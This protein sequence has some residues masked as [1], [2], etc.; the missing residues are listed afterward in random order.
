MTGEAPQLEEPIAPESQEP[1]GQP[2]QPLDFD[3][4]VLRESA[5][6]RQQFDSAHEPR[7]QARVA[8]AEADRL[9]MGD[10][11]T[12]MQGGDPVDTPSGY[13]QFA[14]PLIQGLHQ[15]ALMQRVSY[16]ANTALEQDE[17]WKA[18]QSEWD[19]L[20][21]KPYEAQ[22]ATL[23]D[24]PGQTPEE[25]MLI[26]LQRTPVEVDP[27]WIA[28]LRM[29][30]LTLDSKLKEASGGKVNIWNH[31]RTRYIAT[32]MNREAAQGTPGFLRSGQQDLGVQ[33]V[34][35]DYAVE[36]ALNL[37]SGLLDMPVQVAQGAYGLIGE[38]VNGITGGAVGWEAPHSYIETP[39]GRILPNAERLP[40][41]LEMF[42]GMRALALGDDV[43][44]QMA[45]W[46]A[47][48]EWQAAQQSGFSQV[49][50]GTALV[51]G[52]IVGLSPTVKAGQRIEKMMNKGLGMVG[53]GKASKNAAQSSHLLKVRDTMTAA[54]GQ[55]AALAMQDALIAGRPEKL[56]EATAHGFKSGLI[57]FGIG[58][59]GR[60]VEHLM[61]TRA[62]MPPRVAEAFGAFTE[63]GLFTGTELAEIQGGIWNFIRD[64][65]ADTW[66]E[67]DK[68]LMKNFLG[69][70][71]A[72]GAGLSIGGEVSRER[73]QMARERTE[74]GDLAEKVLQAKEAAEAVPRET[75]EKAKEPKSEL[76]E[77]ELEAF[78]LGGE[79]VR[80]ESTFDIPEG[81]I[82]GRGPVER[83]ASEAPKVERPKD[84]PLVSEAES[85]MLEGV[86]RPEKSEFGEQRDFMETAKPKEAELVDRL[87][88]AAKRGDE[89]EFDRLLDE[90]NR[91]DPT[92]IDAARV[93]KATKSIDDALAAKEAKEVEAPLPKA[94]PKKTAQDWVKRIPEELRREVE[95]M[96]V[97]PE[98]LVRLAQT[99]RKARAGDVQAAMDVREIEQG[100]AARQ[101]AE[102]VSRAEQ[103][104]Q[105]LAEVRRSE[106]ELGSLRAEQEMR[107]APPV[108]GTE[109]IRKVDIFNKM[110]GYREDPIRTVQRKG[111]ISQAI[112][113][114]SPG[115]KGFFDRNRDLIRFRGGDTE[116][117]V[118][119]HEFSHAVQRTAEGFERTLSSP[120]ARVEAER[121]LEGYGAKL[122][123]EGTFAEAFAE[124]H[125]RTILGET[126]MQEK[127]PALTAEFAE[128]MAANPRVNRQFREVVAM[129]ARYRGQGAQN[130]LRQFMF[131][132]GDEVTPEQKK[133]I[134]AS[135]GTPLERLLVSANE[136]LID[137]LAQA[138]RSQAE[139][140]KLQGKDVS[141]IPITQNY[142]RTLE[143]LRNTEASTAANFLEKG[144]MLGGER[145]ASLREAL[146]ELK[147]PEL[148]TS[149][150]A[151][152]VGRRMLEMQDKGMTTGF[153]RAELLEAVDAEARIL[154]GHE[155]ANRMA[156]QVK[157]FFDAMVSWTA[158]EGLLTQT[159]AKEMIDNWSVYVPMVRRMQ[160]SLRSGSPKSGGGLR[161]QRGG[162][163]EIE[164]PFQ[165]ME[166][167]TVA[168]VRA[169]NR[170]KALEA[171]YQHGVSGAR[172]EEVEIL[173]P[174]MLPKEF[175]I[176][177][178]LKAI[179]S[180][181]RVEGDRQQ[182][183]EYSLE[184][185][186]DA[187]GDDA[188]A[189][190]VLFRPNF[191]APGNRPILM[192]RTAQ[193]KR[194]WMQ[195]DK[196]V[197][198]A[199]QTVQHQRAAV[200]AAAKL[201]QAGK[202][203]RAL[204]VPADVVRWWATT[205]NLEFGARNTFRDAILFPGYSKLSRNAWMP[206]AGLAYWLKGFR[207]L[208][209]QS[210]P[211]SLLGK[212]GK[213]AT[214][215]KTA[216]KESLAYS[217][218]TAM[219]ADGLT[220]Y[221]RT[222]QDLRGSDLILP[223]GSM[224][225][226][227]FTAR[228]M[229][230]K[231]RDFL[232]TQLGEVI[233]IGEKSLRFEEFRGVFDRAIKEGKSEAEAGLEALEAS[234]EVMINFTR[235]SMMGRQLNRIIPYW[236]AAI[237]GKRKVFR[238]FTG[239]DGK[240]AQKVAWIN[241]ASTLGVT[242]IFT[243]LMWGQE[244]WFKDLAPWQRFTSW[245]IGPNV[246]LPKPH[247]IG[248]LATAAFDV[249]FAENKMTPQEA[250]RGIGDDWIFD[251][252]ALPAF[253]LPLFENA[254]NF[255]FFKGRQLVPDWME[256]TRLPVDQFDS[257][258]KGWAKW[259]SRAIDD[260]FG[261][262]ISPIK[263]E[264]L[265]NQ[266]LGN[267]PARLERN[268]RGIGQ[269][270]GFELDPNR[271]TLL[272]QI[273]VLS[274]FFRHHPHR[275]GVT[276]SRFE[277]AFKELQQRIGSKKATPQDQS[278]LQWA[279]SIKRQMRDVDSL[280][281]EGAISNE[282]RDALL[283]EL[284]LPFVTEER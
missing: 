278:R 94:K 186:R 26:R 25:A 24:K 147:T 281:R 125:A 176:E 227:R 75:G 22:N 131:K 140:A 245:H 259:A 63:A 153:S 76:S 117:A 198:E 277:A 230:E 195:V 13:K 30:M 104:E 47:D 89:A 112:R 168:M 114:A 268:I 187:L 82:T 179:E 137:D 231:A 273:P 64:P 228:G 3:A 201:E 272:D 122:D 188:A 215:S 7:E 249:M 93:T 171:L 86:K 235:A 279:R 1:I 81:A 41:A 184:I 254:A 8:K 177:E 136:M 246:Q 276:R 256:K 119:A 216:E 58:K 253:M 109:P 247:G 251:Q 124:Y 204:R 132:V 219:G 214:L 133:A 10:I 46:N 280:Y 161:K 19:E 100:I 185:L 38:M 274:S 73:R 108:E 275:A 181:V 34:V 134:E 5:R 70:M 175:Q 16:Q 178:L 6:L 44:K 234:K 77:D 57:M 255:S 143:A 78:G 15:S 50:N 172:A 27:N 102:E 269:G 107:A 146:S 128:V 120:E 55:G 173:R 213:L 202:L 166:Q 28:D 237:Q 4:R 87:E 271:N 43:G 148:R 244:D 40:G 88:E 266:S 65:S 165:A 169:V 264:N 45:K 11:L 36:P 61:R 155:R 130:R 160:E 232:E 205:T 252:F 71:L 190:L 68:I 197:F 154:G 97:D 223:K 53:V 74:Q 157:D 66:A 118:R 222:L 199:L 206:Y 203:F 98:D 258:T 92:K 20:V 32:Y 283:Y 226:K 209:G 106:G 239:L 183:L 207:E 225:P 208:V 262:G 29:R 163:E 111:R 121:M 35:L 220:F 270:L 194:V 72:R 101:V 250:M 139:H 80:G 150:A 261:I 48:R 129:A 21:M 115:V 91:S 37:T 95:L 17:D 83:P 69:I 123:A 127:F 79:Q 14:H 200:G 54:L 39:D 90:V 9:M 267:M 174:E 162:T 218:F 105:E 52:S 60:G 62:K 212:A 158:Q 138:K 144:V 233:D 248:P 96:N 236:N 192:H 113:G 167:V 99:R 110:A 196:P 151:Y 42:V 240:E 33:G 126:R 191:Q 210:P 85:A 84:E 135:E 229:I 145:T 257:Y 260:A 142:L 180:Q 141:D 51:G 263:L 12:A 265:V 182:E 241:A 31:P 156:Q 224:V 49:V 284:T 211:R 67:W 217:W 282:R 23:P 149:F 221:A 56:A 103:I 164:D 193:G 189:S 18:I 238:A 242:S 243:H 116:L 2:Q 170:H 59:A 152:L 159:E